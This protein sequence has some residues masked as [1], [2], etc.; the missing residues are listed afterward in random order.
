MADMSIL[1]KMGRP[2]VT[3]VKKIAFDAA[4]FL[5][6]HTGKCKNTH[7]HRWEVEIGVG[8][9][10]RD[11][12]MVIDFSE[13]SMFLD[14]V[15]ELYD[16][17]DLNNIMENPTAENIAMDIAEKWSEE[18]E[19][20]GISLDFIRVWETPTS[21]VIYSPPEDLGDGIVYPQEVQRGG[22]LLEQE[23]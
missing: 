3:V 19:R 16:H 1:E 2:Y 4:H 13:V 15:K 12:G 17:K 7:G 10:V 14:R 6:Y 8:G 18:E 22:I 21:H 20:E 11:D 5:P 9:W 23:M